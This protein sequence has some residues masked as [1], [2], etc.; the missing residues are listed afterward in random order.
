MKKGKLKT[1]FIKTF[2]RKY[3]NQTKA[4]ILDL[5]LTNISGTNYSKVEREGDNKL[6]IEGSI[7]E[8]FRNNIMSLWIGFCR[9]A[10]LYFDKNNYVIYSVDY[11]YGA[12]SIFSG[13]IILII[14]PFLFFQHLDKD[15]YFG[16]LMWVLPGFL[17]FGV[18][19]NA[20]RLYLHRKVFLDTVNAKNR[21]KGSYDW[22]RILKEKSDKELKDLINGNTTLTA[23][24]Q[25]MAEE[26]LKR[27]QAF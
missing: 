12:V 16:F 24:V 8:R 10:E 3:Q 18:L 20:Y 23:E 4:E 22:S 13:L 5:F 26:E 2:R 19:Y 9:R 1:P 15:E 14:F 6:I 11:T 21:F 17:V 27:R 7:Y 25:K